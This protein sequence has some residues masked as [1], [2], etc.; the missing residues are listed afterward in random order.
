MSCAEQSG[1]VAFPRVGATP[2]SLIG[3]EVITMGIGT[4]ASFQGTVLATAVPVPEPASMV[5]MGTGLVGLAAMVRRRRR[6]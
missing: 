6:A 3:Q 2:Y 5:L 1:N 4:V